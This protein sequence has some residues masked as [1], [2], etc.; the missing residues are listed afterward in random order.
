M[1]RFS[2]IVGIMALV[3]F[4]SVLVGT[5]DP[6][7][8]WGYGCGHHGKGFWTNLTEEQ[9]EAV[10]EKKEE[11]RSQGAT[12]E[13]IRA[14]VAELLEG[15]SV[16][17]PENW[18]RWHGPKGFGHRHGGFWRNLTDEQRQALREKK[19]ELRSQSATHEEIRA[20][21]AEMLEGYGVELPEDWPGPHGRGGF[22]PGPGGFWEDL[23]KEQR[24]AVREKIR[25]MRSQDASREEIRAAIDEMLQEY[26]FDLPEKSESTSSEKTTA[27]LNIQ[28]QSYPNPFNPETQIAYTLSVSEKVRIQI[29]NVTGQLIRTYDLGYQPAGSYSVHWDGRNENGDIT[30]SGV[31]LYRI[32]GGPYEVTNRMVLLK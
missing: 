13:E 9:R 4:V 24:E 16:E 25:E 11:M 31:Y 8:A 26:G 19:E 27:E 22:G 2:S 21:V 1:K 7:L 5:S 10:Q 6:V 14:A 18:D 29:Y 12:R 28:A 3:L 30:A 20:A 15:Y 17:L 23:T 32:E